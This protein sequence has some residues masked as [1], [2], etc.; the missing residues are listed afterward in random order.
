MKLL[1]VTPTKREANILGKVSL[2]CGGGPSAGA[3]VDAYLGKH[4]VDA[5]VLA[6][7]CGGLD[8][9][10][11]AGDLILAR[12]AVTYDGSELEPD[13]VLFE[14]ARRALRAGGPPFI[15]SLLLSLERPAA[16]G[17]EKLE[18]W[19]RFG[20]AGVDMETAAVADAASARGV[21]WLALRSVLDPAGATLPSAVREW[22]GEGDEGWIARRL[23][24]TPRDWPGTARLAIEMR[25]ALASLRQ[26]VPPV[27]RALSALVDVGATGPAESRLA[28]QR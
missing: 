9:S 19:N 20:A 28:S 22:Q 1:L 12:R 6:G 18:L 17:S 13:P 10:L 21:R 23:A 16:L 25:R 27:V 2:I 14:V 5:L 15:S 8:P 11:L 24:R 26:G 3:V 4:P 7:V